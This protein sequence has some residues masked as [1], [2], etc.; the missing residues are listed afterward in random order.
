MGVAELLFTS[1]AVRSTADIKG[2]SALLPF[3]TAS[4]D[5]TRPVINT[6]GIESRDFSGWVYVEVRREH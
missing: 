6:T 4:S 1:V 3:S 5:I 2:S